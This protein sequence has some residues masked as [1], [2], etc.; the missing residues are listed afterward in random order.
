MTRKI[1]YIGFGGIVEGYHYKTAR[2]EDVPFTPVAV[3]DID[4]LRREAA[5]KEGLQTFDRLEDFLASR[6]FDLVVVGVPNQYHCPYTC[7]ALRA[8]Y[9]VLCEKPVAMNMEELDRMIAAA[10]ESGRMFTVHQNRRF[11][12]DAL[13]AKE[14]LASGKLGNLISLEARV[15]SPGGNGQMFGWRMFADHGGGFFGDWG[16]HVLDQVLDIIREPVRSVFAVSKTLGT[17]DAGED[18]TKILI[19]FE[20]GLSA[21]VEAS[22]FTPLPL[23]K[24]MIFGD[25]GVFR[26]DEAYGASGRVRSVKKS[27]AEDKEA[28]VYPDEA[29]AKRSYAAITVEEWEDETVPKGEIT[30]DWAKLYLNLAAYLDGREPLAVTPESVLRCFRVLEAARTSAKTG[31]AVRFD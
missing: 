26:M 12:R 5:Q 20:S 31:N 21:Q 7:A 22:D 8:G 25:R 6:L 14:V 30:Q 3:Y 19:T 4:P 11:D 15:H 18:Y 29:V 17:P 24:W 27:R 2:R 16:I 23:P 28:S 9:H 1:G 13:I 10:R